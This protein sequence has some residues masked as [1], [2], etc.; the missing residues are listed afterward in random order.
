MM[1]GLASL[2][3]A[4]GILAAPLAAGAK[5]LERLTDRSDILGW[6]AVGR[7]DNEG[8]GYCSAALIAPNLVLTAAHCMFEPD[9]SDRVDPRNLTFFAGLRDG[10]SIASQQVARAVVLPGFD[11]LDPGAADSVRHDVALLELEAPIPATT[12]DPYPLARRV[13]EGQRVTVLSY[14]LGRSNAMSRETGCTV[15]AEGRGLIAFDC[16]AHPGSSGAPIFDTSGRSPRILSIV[17]GTGDFEGK[18]AVFGM[19]L[20]SMVTRL[21]NAMRIGKGVW[22]GQEPTKR[23]VIGLSERGAGSARFLKPGSG[24]RTRP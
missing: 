7:L 19:N 1:R 6:E 5:Q 2:A 17:S 10:Q 14:G 15:L 24:L 12:A 9:S 4:A 18:D 3:F 23:R 13:R 20:P 22:P 8:R 21:R 11:P 16:Q